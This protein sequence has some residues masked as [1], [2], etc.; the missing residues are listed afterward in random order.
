MGFV[1]AYS[2]DLSPAYA[3]SGRSGTRPTDEEIRRVFDPEVWTED[4]T[5]SSAFSNSNFRR[6][7]ETEDSLF[8][9]SPRFVEHIDAKAVSALTS[10]HS[11][12]LE[13]IG[14]KLYN[15]RRYPIHV[16]DLC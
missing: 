5:Q 13:A 2:I 12:E 8:Y 6:L 7:D 4:S 1:S 10:F 9:T 15:D 11:K 14:L 16:L 3:A